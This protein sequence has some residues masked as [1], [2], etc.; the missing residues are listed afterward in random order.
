[1]ARRS[2]G[3]LQG[4][5][6]LLLLSCFAWMQAQ[7]I[8]HNTKINTLNDAVAATLNYKDA[9]VTGFD[10]MQ[11]EDHNYVVVT[12]KGINEADEKVEFVAA[13]YET[14]IE[15][16]NSLLDSSE[17]ITDTM[18]LQDYTDIVIDKLLDVVETA[19]LVG[20]AE[21]SDITYTN[22]GDG[23]IL[24]VSAPKVE[25]D[26][27]YY[28]IVSLHEGVNEKG[29]TGLITHVD[30]VSFKLTK[31]IEKD[32]S[33]IFTLGTKGA[34]IEAMEHKFA[35]FDTQNMEMKVHNQFNR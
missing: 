29:D 22:E 6:F 23:Q 17:Y 1:M 20:K 2:S 11:E 24:T 15:K 34:T 8:K 28:Y 14:D 13:K 7:K 10:L 9:T 26:Q 12:A 33:V 5:W 25:G 16:Y 32:P 30:K 21:R 4:A 31:E 27:A 18:S 3:N 35:Q 19:K